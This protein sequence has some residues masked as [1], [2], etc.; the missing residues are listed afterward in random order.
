MIYY[1]SGQNETVLKIS[2]SS[3]LNFERKEHANLY[4]LPLYQ[5]TQPSVQI[6]KSDP[7]LKL[8]SQIIQVGG[9]S[10]YHPD[11]PP[12]QSRASFT[13]SSSCSQLHLA[14]FSVSPGMEVDIIS[15]HLLQC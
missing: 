11:Q 15:G 8:K 2:L 1:P 4:L 7:F 3:P 5:G 13:V 6:L 14:S 10:G 9:V 12:A